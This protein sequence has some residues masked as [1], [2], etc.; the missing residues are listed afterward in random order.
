M[1]M[2]CLTKELLAHIY[3]DIVLL[4][5]VTFGKIGSISIFVLALTLTLRI[6]L[7]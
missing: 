5:F 3:L 7:Q 4:P 6:V 2:D 1:R